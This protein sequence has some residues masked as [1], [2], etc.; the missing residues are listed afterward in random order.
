MPSVALKFRTPI[1]VVFAP[2]SERIQPDNSYDVPGFTET[3]WLTPAGGP[4]MSTAF[5]S[6][7]TPVTRTELDTGSHASRFG[8][9]KSPSVT[10]S[11]PTG[12]GVPTGAAGVL[13]EPTGVP[14]VGDANGAV[15]AAAGALG[16]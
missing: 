10:R 15:V 2:V 1:I 14:A 3:V 12:P 5:D 6:P 11:G 8:S 4:S 16:R 13:A 9:V 7:C